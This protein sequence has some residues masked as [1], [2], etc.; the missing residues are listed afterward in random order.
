[1]D[2]EAES[3]K[4]FKK[5]LNAS[6]NYFNDKA[7]PDNESDTK[8]HERCSSIEKAKKYCPERWKALQSWFREARM[9]R[10]EANM[11]T[12]L[13]HKHEYYVTEWYFV[14]TPPSQE[15]RK[16]RFYSK[17]TTSIPVIFIGS[18]PR[19]DYLPI[20]TTLLSALIPFFR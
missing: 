2:N 17:S 9:V 10:I 20:M 14:D 18:P 12:A 16:L 19:S 15:A 13:S 4:E 5:K 11:S 6:D 3:I 8:A 1:M 7:F